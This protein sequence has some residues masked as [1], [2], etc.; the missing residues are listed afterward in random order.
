MCFAQGPPTQVIKERDI[1]N[2]T[3]YG[4]DEQD[5]VIRVH[6]LVGPHNLVQFELVKLENVKWHK[7]VL[8][9]GPCSC[10]VQ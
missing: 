1:Y 3:L 4:Q 8:A 6:T 9:T 10:H 2:P 7:Q 5:N